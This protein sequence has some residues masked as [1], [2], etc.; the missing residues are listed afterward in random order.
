MDDS[1]FERDHAA[2]GGLSFEGKKRRRRTTT[3]ARKKRGRTS[4]RPSCLSPVSWERASYPPCATRGRVTC[5]GTPRSCRG[6]HGSSPPSR[7]GLPLYYSQGDDGDDGD[8]EVGTTGANN[9]A[10]AFLGPEARAFERASGG[11]RP[12]TTARSKG[13]DEGGGA[14]LLLSGGGVVVPL[15]AD[16]VLLEAGERNES[17]GDR[18]E[19]RTQRQRQQPRRQQRQERGSNDVVRSAFDS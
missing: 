6:A 13:G 2:C 12:S 19:G 15:H 10:T 14:S 7:R 17:G 4:A 1:R 9:A 3:T 16:A 8:D 11:V 5:E 18:T